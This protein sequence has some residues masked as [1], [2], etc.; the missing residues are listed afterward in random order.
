[1]ANLQKKGLE[2]S[3]TSLPSNQKTPENNLQ[4]KIQE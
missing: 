2:K 4:K 1:M 3:V